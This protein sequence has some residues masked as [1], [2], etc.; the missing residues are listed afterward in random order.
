M[1]GYR[2]LF[3]TDTE[4]LL[5]E[6]NTLEQQ[7]KSIYTNSSATSASQYSGHPQQPQMHA[8]MQPG[9]HMHQ[10][11]QQQQP[12]SHMY[13]AA[14]A[15]YQSQQYMSQQQ[16]QQ[17][18]SN[19]PISNMMVQ[20]QQQQNPLKNQ[21]INGGMP[22]VNASSYM[23]S[24]MAPPPPPQP[25][26]TSGSGT[27]PPQS[28]PSTAAGGQQISAPPPTTTTIQNV[29]INV[30]NNFNI[31]KSMQQANLSQFNQAPAN[32]TANPASNVNSSLSTANPWSNSTQYQTMPPQQQ[33]YKQ[34]NLIQQQQQQ[35]YKMNQFN[36]QKP[37]TPPQLMPPTNMVPNA[38][39]V[40]ANPAIGAHK[41]SSAA[42]PLPNMGQQSLGSYPNQTVNP[43]QQQQQQQQPQHP[44]SAYSAHS[45]MN[46]VNTNGSM[47]PVVQQPL[48]SN[49]NLQQVQSPAGPVNP[50]AAAK[51]S[52]LPPHMQPQQ[53]P[54]QYPGFNAANGPPIQ[55]QQAHVQQ[56]QQYQPSPN[57]I[58]NN[59]TYSPSDYNQNMGP[60]MGPISV[61]QTCNTNNPNKPQLSPNRAP[62]NSYYGQGTTPQQQQQP[63]QNPAY[64]QYQQPQHNQYMPP[65][66]QQYAAYGTQN[67]QLPVYGQPAQTPQTTAQMNNVSNRANYTAYPIPQQQQQQ[68]QADHINV[69]QQQPVSALSPPSGS[70]QVTAAAAATSPE[71]TTPTKTGR[72][73]GKAS[74]GATSSPDDDT[75]PTKGKRATKAAKKGAEQLVAEQQQTSASSSPLQQPL[76]SQ[77]PIY[78]QP[79][80]PSRPPSQQQHQA[81]MMSAASSSPSPTNRNIYPTT[82][83]PPAT[84]DML[85][86]QGMASPS[87]N[88]SSTGVMHQQ[89]PQQ[90]QQQQASPIN[91][92][93][94]CYSSMGP[95][96]MTA[97]LNPHAG[98]QQQQQQP[99]GGQSS[100]SSVSPNTPLNSQPMNPMN[101][102]MN[103]AMS[104]MNYN[105]ASAY[106]LGGQQ[107]V[108]AP[109]G[110]M[111]QQPFNKAPHMQQQT[112]M[113]IVQMQ[114][115]QFPGQ[116]PQNSFQLQ[117]NMQG[118]PASYSTNLVNPAQPNAAP[119]NAQQLHN[120]V[121]SPLILSQLIDQFYLFFKI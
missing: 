10:Q 119:M 91:S 29:Q 26:P 68:Q 78:Q 14:A 46:Y 115:P 105:Q 85:G 38:P 6:I 24:P 120:R 62:V 19:Q 104:N 21:N 86:G 71:V 100:A 112:A 84:V 111:Q 53:Q 41:P 58:V 36:G 73:K 82:T 72:G 15:Q 8:Q 117:Q 93:Q 28:P 16:Q 33:Q 57:K 110:N 37:S 9:Q 55:R 87:A 95:P 7:Q 43:A 2:S 34:A 1:D 42:S 12:Q 49:S 116:P 25:P 51:M 89:Q 30:Q 13:S 47:Q 63:Q 118:N 56:Q 74:K 3:D 39:G 70:P 5:N 94:G 114:T 60:N 17:Y 90:Q 97:S 31:A 65:H 18:Y 35:V 98:M 76:Q 103:P 20:P 80:Q 54:Q 101:P 81:Y 40:V 113:P 59:Q 11:P 121:I 99:F 77:Q 50:A 92:T 102:A 23:H 45:Q 52:S 67:K 75:K 106:Q 27:V 64:S 88:Y 107:A 61:N 66:Q 109:N 108:Y 96:P 32:P 79:Q 22:T 48:I 69:Q 4:S 44:H 83:Q